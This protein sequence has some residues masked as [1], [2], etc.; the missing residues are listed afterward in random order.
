MSQQ[1][2]L[3]FSSDESHST[4][5][6]EGL[7]YFPSFID[8]RMHN[9]LIETID[10]Q[11]WENSLMRRVQQYGYR[12][13]YKNRTI[14]KADWLGP[15]PEWTAR[16]KALFHQQNVFEA[17]TDQMI[18]NEYLPGQGIA[19]HIDRTTCF[20]ETIAILSLGSPIIMDFA[21]AY[22]QDKSE[23]LLESC[24]LL[25]LKGPARYEWKHGIAARKTDRFQGD[26]FKRERRISLTFRTA[27][28]E[29]RTR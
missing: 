13:D 26:S 7:C 3:V 9:R 18:V 28:D 29:V 4:L 23:V 21:H 22:S 17:C 15:L 2:R 16:T 8:A 25:V 24:S 27:L 19:S 11:S 14:G 12:Y 10:K 1:K 20:G 6:I 5:E